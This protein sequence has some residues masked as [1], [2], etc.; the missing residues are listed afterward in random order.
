MRAYRVKKVV[1]QDGCV[2]LEALPFQAGETVE[3]IVLAVEPA[4]EQET[5]SRSL[6]DSVLE[7]KEPTEP[8]AVDDWDAFQFPS[9]PE[10]VS[11]S[12]TTA[13]SAPLRPF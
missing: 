8:V 7:Y 12:G 11:S 3:I 13:R 9:R 10:R 4:K 2:Q 5:A 1:T 6:K